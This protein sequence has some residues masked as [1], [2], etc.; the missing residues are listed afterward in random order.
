MV[1]Q[2]SGG[3]PPG[4]DERALACGHGHGRARNDARVL[5][6]EGRHITGH[7]HLGVPVHLKGHSGATVAHAP[8]SVG[9]DERANFG[10]EKFLV[11]VEAACDRF[12]FTVQRT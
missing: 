8:V 2:V 9:D 7:H 12:P 10:A 5:V 11:P 4:L 6:G 1:V 3:R